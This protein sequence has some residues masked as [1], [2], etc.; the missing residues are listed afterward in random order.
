[1]CMSLREI[2]SL[3]CLI[4]VL[5]KTN[6]VIEIYAKKTLGIKKSFFENIEVIILV[7]KSNKAL[8]ISKE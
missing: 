8:I 2:Q 5:N 6:I 3:F 4:I 1:M 7:F